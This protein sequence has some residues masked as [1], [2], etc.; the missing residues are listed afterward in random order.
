MPHTVDVCAKSL[1]RRPVNRNKP[2]R[3]LR[4]HVGHRFKNPTTEWANWRH[5]KPVNPLRACESRGSRGFWEGKK[6]RTTLE[7]LTGCF[8]ET[9]ARDRIGPKGLLQFEHNLRS[10][11]GNSTNTVRKEMGRLRPIVKQAIRD[12]DLPPDGYLERVERDDRRLPTKLF[13]FLPP[14]Y[15]TETRTIRVQEDVPRH[16]PN[17]KRS[18]AYIFTTDTVDADF[19]GRAIEADWLREKPVLRGPLSSDLQVIVAEGTGPYTLT[20]PQIDMDEAV[21]MTQWD[22]YQRHAVAGE[23]FEDFCLEEHGEAR[24][25]DELIDPDYVMEAILGPS[26][27]PAGSAY[28]A[29]EEYLA[30]VGP[31]G[32][33]PGHELV[34]GASA[35]SFFDAAMAAAMNPVPPEKRDS[36]YPLGW[37]IGHYGQLPGSNYVGIEVSGPVGLSCFQHVLDCAGAKIRLEL[38]RTGERLK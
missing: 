19:A 35:A 2:A 29:L 36:P 34:A 14:G 3:Q 18:V 38:E 13:P 9:I 10:E 31:M 17:I 30:C 22:Y 16:Q 12:A 15:G 27:F 28:M 4:F 20:D 6:Y 1:R 26:E 7:K 23:S 5:F 21:Q 37:V 11:Y 8:G 24:D 32:G 25:P 33:V